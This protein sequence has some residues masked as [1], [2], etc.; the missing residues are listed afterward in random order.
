MKTLR[1]H[2]PRTHLTYSEKE[3]WLVL[4]KGENCP[5]C[6]KK[7]EIEKSSHH[8]FDF[9]GQKEEG[10]RRHPSQLE[11][12][13][14]LHPECHHRIHLIAGLIFKILE[15]SPQM[16]IEILVGKVAKTLGEE[17]EK[18]YWVIEKE[19]VKA[20]LVEIKEG[21][22]RILPEGFKRKEAIKSY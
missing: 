21:E 18:V 4:E 19:M 3:A 8:H 12:I 7:I 22:L 6:S 17:P 20:K 14:R 15:I 16:K 11:L 2:R 5:F 1:G 9:K 13:H 10:G